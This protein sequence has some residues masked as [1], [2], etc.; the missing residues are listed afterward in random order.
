MDVSVNSEAFQG[1]AWRQWGPKRVALT[2]LWPNC[3]CLHL[4]ARWKSERKI[5]TGFQSAEKKDALILYFLCTNRKMI[6]GEN[7]VLQT[8]RSLLLVR[9]TISSHW[10]KLDPCIVGSVASILGCEESATHQ[11]RRRLNNFS[12]VGSHFC[13][14]SWLIVFLNYHIGRTYHLK[15][16]SKPLSLHYIKS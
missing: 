10:S 1:A 14:I 5:H 6:Q 12:T 15:S 9:A 7:G 11:L 3:W 4:D 13:L 8:E 16:Y 2:D